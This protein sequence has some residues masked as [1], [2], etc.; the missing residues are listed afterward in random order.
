MTITATLK[1]WTVL[2]AGGNM[3]LKGQA[4]SHVNPDYANDGDVIITSVVWE[5][6][7]GYVYCADGM[8]KLEG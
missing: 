6:R 7:D 4:F 3:Y 5:G 1:N 2:K 8:Y